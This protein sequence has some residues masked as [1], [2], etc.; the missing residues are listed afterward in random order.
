MLGTLN[1]ILF[2]P[3][4]LIHWSCNVNSTQSKKK[5]TQ[6]NKVYAFATV[7]CNYKY[8]LWSSLLY[9]EPTLGFISNTYDDYNPGINQSKIMQGFARVTESNWDI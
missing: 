4:K 8:F 7:L 6:S 3:K 1:I 9:M 2:L 5:K